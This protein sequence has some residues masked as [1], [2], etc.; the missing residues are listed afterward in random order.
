MA[1]SRR[2]SAA[3]SST[4]TRCFGVFAAATMRRS[5]EMGVQFTLDPSRLD[6]CAF[7][8]RDLHF[9]SRLSLV[10]RRAALMLGYFGNITKRDARE[11]VPHNLAPRF[12]RGVGMN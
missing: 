2:S 1:V 7:V 9:A 4:E 11:G 8:H 6:H 10:R 3:S 12:A 5:L